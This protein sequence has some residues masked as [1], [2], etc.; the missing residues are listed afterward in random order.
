MSPSIGE[1][2]ADRRPPAP[3]QSRVAG[4]GAA[5]HAHPQRQPPLADQA[6]A[7]A[8]PLA[9][10]LEQA[11]PVLGAATELARA[12]LGRDVGRARRRPARG[13][14][15][16]RGSCSTRSGTRRASAPGRRRPRSW[17]AAPRAC[18]APL[19]YQRRRRAGA[20]A[21]CQLSTGM[22][23]ALS[24]LDVL[25]HDYE[26][27]A[28]RSRRAGGAPRRGRRR[29]R[30]PRWRRA[31]A[32]SSPSPCARARARAAGSRR[33]SAAA[34]CTCAGRARPRR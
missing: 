20:S 15:G 24:C 7:L 27:R 25:A 1:L 30:A 22:P 21:S 8:E 13:A 5:E 19:S 17:P 23:L 32:G 29:G 33:S 3:G 34:S 31:D 12:L 18:P 16:G 26:L 6:H 28:R 4:V 11:G 2:G 10:G 9:P 14:H